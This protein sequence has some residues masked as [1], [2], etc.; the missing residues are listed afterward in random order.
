MEAQV[1]NLIAPPLLESGNIQIVP[2]RDL[3]ER[4]YIDYSMSVIA[5]RA[6]PDVRDGLKPVHR[7]I[8]YAMHEAGND[9]NKAYRKSA[10]MVGDV[11]G[12]YHPHGDVS[13]YDA[14]ARMAQPF[15]MNEVL[16]D[17]QGNFGSIDGDNPAAMRYT[18]MRMTRLTSEMFAD[19]HKDTVAWRDNYDASEKEPEVLTAPYPLLLVNGGEGVAVGMAYKIPPHNLRQ[20]IQAT[21]LMLSNPH[22]ENREIAAALG[23]PDFPTRGIVHGLDGFA[24]AVSTGRGSV[25]I[26]ARWHEE[27]RN[28][29]GKSLVIDEI[30]YQV[31]KAK[32][33]TRI[34]E[35]VRDKEIEGITDLRDESNKDGMRVVIEVRRD[36]SPEAIFSALCS[37]TDM[38]IS[39]SYN[40]VVID[41][42]IPRLMGLRDILAAWISFRQEV[43]LAR[44][45]YDRKQAQAKLHLLAGYMAAIA[46]MDQV[47]AA[48]RAADNGADAKAALLA[49]LG[50]ADDQ[51]DAILALRLQKLTGMEL[52]SIQDEF[53]AVTARIS[54]LSLII[55]SPER[56]IEVIQH[57]L[58]ELSDRYGRDRQTEIGHDISAITRADMIPCEDVVILMTKNG[59]IKRMPVSTLGA[60]NRGT[61]GRRS[62]EVD[63]DDE[64]LAIY[65]ANTHD[66]ILIF[67]SEGQVYSRRGYQIPEASSASRGR[68]IKQV[69]DGFEREIAA[70]VRVPSDLQSPSIVI[71]T[72]D[73]TVKRSNM[74]VYAS[75]DRK[76]GVRGISLDGNKIVTAMLAVDGQHLMMIA[77]GGNA[78]RFDL[79]ELREIGRTGQGVRGMRLDEGEVIVGAHVIDAESTDHIVCIGERGVGKRTSVSEFKLQ[80][81]AGSGVR[82]FNI[83]RKTGFLIAAFGADESRDII[84]LSSNGV[85]NRIPVSSIRET[86]RVAAGTILM[87]LDEGATVVSVTTV[88]SASANGEGESAN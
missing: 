25:K 37:K 59:Y 58:S 81:R 20:V 29:G 17:G 63:A 78:I 23:A 31:I 42:G 80:G 18:E 45:V 40:C 33:V 65:E 28:R 66:S 14:A 83:N 34:A 54:E 73:G 85:S 26:R 72:S 82:A 47:I 32:L 5:G 50:L 74:E 12:K 68:H 21:L 44:Y 24:D 11:I 87:N 76:G 70:I 77:S 7:R 55:D 41:R 13:V 9:H 69:I 51:V 67:D 22:V 1:N 71:V 2:V 46:R 16:I 49:L 36:E 75:A 86:G 48:I 62:I 43:V 3:M 57:E 64:I 38:E 88:V 61:R 10:R 52:N 53:N 19:L 27:E 60:Q 4:S 56:I 30:P 15:S 6:L 79:S 39:F 8:L 84:L 35:L